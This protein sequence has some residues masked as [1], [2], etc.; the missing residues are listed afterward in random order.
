[1]KILYFHQHFNTPVGTVGVRSY[2]MARALVAAGHDVTMVCGSY[3]GGV[4]GLSGPYVK[5]RRTGQV[6][7]VNVIELELPYSNA[8]GF[9]GRVA[10]FLKF[11]LRSAFIAL[12]HSYDV[13][14]ATSTPLTAA[15]PGI[16]ARWLRGKPFV[17]EVRDLW[18]E[19]PRA[20]GVIKNP[21]ILGAMSV[22]EWTS[23]RSATRLVA[24]AGG[25]A[26]GIAE[27]GVARARIKTI[28]NGCDLDI[29]GGNPAPRRP[30]GVLANDLMALFAGTHGVANGLDAV[31]DAALVLKQRGR[32]DIKIVLIGDGKCKPSLVERAATADL[33]NVIF[34]DPIGKADLSKIL[35]AT[36]VGLQI[37]ANVPAF[38][39][40]TSPNKFFDYLAAGLPVLNNYPGWV[41]DMIAAEKCGFVVPGDDAEAFADALESAADDRNQL[42]AMG[43]SSLALAKR[44]FDRTALAADFVSWVVGAKRA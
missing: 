32:S 14:F 11:A 2:Q 24:L 8:L 28:P 15:I 9:F 20:M 26:N 19:L 38:F 33:S 37:L 6:E 39:Y 17:F 4:T 12:S 44:D 41:A 21:I 30:S 7:G 40:G 43:A 13:V 3:E 22:L 36:D 23:Y 27:R 31:L 18:P 16:L 1:M 42:R 25:I 34:L 35:A 5:G 10:V 29:F